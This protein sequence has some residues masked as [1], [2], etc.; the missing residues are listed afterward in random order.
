MNAHTLGKATK[1]VGKGVGRCFCIG[2]GGEMA[3]F[4]S[5]TGDGI[6]YYIGADSRGKYGRIVAG[7]DGFYSTG[8]VGGGT[9]VL[10]VYCMGTLGDEAKV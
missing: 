4:Q 1:V 2:T 8:G 6:N 5:K 3:L 10:W 9:S 7:Q